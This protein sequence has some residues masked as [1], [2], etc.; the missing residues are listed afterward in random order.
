[1]TPNISHPSTLIQER[2]INEDCGESNATE[3]GTGRYT[4]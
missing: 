1:M 2:N 3:T 4:S